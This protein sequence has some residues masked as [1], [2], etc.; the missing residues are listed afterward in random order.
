MPDAGLMLDL[1][2]ILEI[3]VTEQANKMLLRK[4]RVLIGL[5]VLVLCVCPFIYKTYIDSP[6]IKGIVTGVM[7]VIF[8]AIC[9]ICLRI[10]QKAGYFECGK[11]S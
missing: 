5:L 11:R 1:C 3:S 8:F 10:E 9:F 4:E 6:L 7:I 2:N